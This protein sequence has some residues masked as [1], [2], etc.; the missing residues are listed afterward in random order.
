MQQP[1]EIVGGIGAVVAG[2][3]LL[4]QGEE[5][6]GVEEEIGQL[7][8]GLGVGDVVLLQVA[9]QA[10][11]GGPVGTGGTERGWRQN[12]SI[13]EVGKDPQVPSTRPTS[14]TRA[15][16]A[17]SGHSSDTTSSLGSPCQC[18]ITLPWTRPQPSKDAEDGGIT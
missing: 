17:T 12:P 9:V 15:L 8:D 10:A 18:L 7:K 16:S 13:A 4:G 2:I 14:S 5:G 11:P 3:E 6:L 1:E